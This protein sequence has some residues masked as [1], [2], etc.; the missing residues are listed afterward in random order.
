VVLAGDELVEEN[1]V[2]RDVEMKEVEQVMDRVA[3]GFIKDFRLE[4]KEGRE[5]YEKLKPHGYPILIKD[6]TMT[7]GLGAIDR[8]EVKK[9]EKKELKDEIFLPPVGY[10]KIVPEP[11]K[12]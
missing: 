1:W 6:Y 2:T 9:V 12:K 5:I 3:Q 4:M 8:V 7:Y 10:Q 11:G